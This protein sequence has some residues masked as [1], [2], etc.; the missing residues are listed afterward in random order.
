VAGAL[1]VF[2]ALAYGIVKVIEKSPRARIRDQGNSAVPF[3]GPDPWV[4]VRKLDGNWGRYA[5]ERIG[6][7]IDLPSEPWADFQSYTAEEARWLTGHFNYFGKVGNRYFNVYG[8]R[9]RNTSDATTEH[10][11]G[12]FEYMFT[13][14]PAYRPA[15]FSRKPFLLGAKRALLISG[16]YRHKGQK[17]FVE[18]ATFGHHGF[19]IAVALAADR[20]E[21]L[22]DEH[23]KIVRSIDLHNP[24]DSLSGTQVGERGPR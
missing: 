12:T 21:G 24:N 13:S 17:W 6:F 11:A 7:A 1:A 3:I 9:E 19:G 14:D 20:P 22:K 15:S 8:L 10:A 4:P 23:M 18:A 5:L 2:G 16:S